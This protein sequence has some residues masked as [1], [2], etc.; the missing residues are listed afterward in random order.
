MIN[1]EK[2]LVNTEPVRCVECG[3]LQPTIRQP[4][5]WTELLWGGWTCSQCGLPMDKWG[6]H[7]REEPAD[8]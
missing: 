2:W 5:S 8:R 6:R 1:W 4:K 3:L 7:R